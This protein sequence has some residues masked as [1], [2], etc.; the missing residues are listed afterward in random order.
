MCASFLNSV[1]TFSDEILLEFSDIL[2]EPTKR[3]IEQGGGDVNATDNGGETVLYKVCCSFSQDNYKQNSRLVNR[4]L[5]LGANPC[6]LPRGS[7]G[8]SYG[9]ALR[10]IVE[11]YAYG[12][13]ISRK[14]NGVSVKPDDPGPPFTPTHRQ[15]MVK[16]ID[17]LLSDGIDM[18]CYKDGVSFLWFGNKT[19]ELRSLFRKHILSESFA[20]SSIVDTEKFFQEV[21]YCF[22]DEDIPT[23]IAWLKLWITQIERKFGYDCVFTTESVFKRSDMRAFSKL[24]FWNNDKMA[25]EILK[26]YRKYL[27]EFRDIFKISNHRP[28]FKP[29]NLAYISG[30]TKLLDILRKQGTVSD[31]NLDAFRDCFVIQSLC[32]FSGKN[33]KTLEYSEISN[34]L[35]TSDVD[36]ESIDLLETV[37]KF[38]DPVQ[39]YKM[40]DHTMHNRSNL[41][42]ILG[43]IG[44]KKGR[45][46][47]NEKQTRLK[48]EIEKTELVRTLVDRG[49]SLHTSTDQDK[50]R[51]SVNLLDFLIPLAC[52]QA[53]VYHLFRAGASLRFLSD[54]CDLLYRYCAHRSHYTLKEKLYDPERFKL[55]L[56]QAVVLEGYRVS[57]DDLERIKNDDEEEVMWFS[58]AMDTPLSLRCL[59]RS[60][61]RTELRRHSNNRT[62][63]PGIESLPVPDLLKQYIRYEGIMCEIEMDAVISGNVFD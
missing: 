19:T 15:R 8:R 43:E 21:A 40:G 49:C 48:Y 22:C 50:S 59:S 32:N 42:R 5:N 12:H 38:F 9:Y 7:V 2:K 63:L 14:E 27:L 1:K 23:L 35:L 46:T 10:L 52:G 6:I 53:I 33:K 55:V 61:V 58:Q 37:M 16:I 57:D 11:R 3:L 56:C 29:F 20:V 47:K 39:R 31:C 24:L 13:D 60:V 25:G 51:N 44:V 18:N 17:E 62:I 4:L 26:Q 28:L 34:Q 54:K 30:K 36:M 45:S 41:G